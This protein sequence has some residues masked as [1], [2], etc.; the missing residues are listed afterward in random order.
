MEGNKVLS[1]AEIDA[2]LSGDSASEESPE[3]T[4]PPIRVVQLD[5]ATEPPAAPAP[6]PIPVSPSMPVD[7]E[8]GLDQL[9][10]PGTTPNWPED[11]AATLEAVVATVTALAQQL[12]TAEG[13]LQQFDQLQMDVSETSIAVK[14]M[15]QGFQAVEQ[16]IQALTSQVQSTLEGLKG[17]FGYRAK[18]TFTCDSCNTSGMVATRIKCTGCGKENWWGWWPPQ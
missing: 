4:S 7:S 12:G 16:Q 13:T 14:E 6:I 10:A 11:P 3:E 1:Q 2:M 8:N 9:A 15:K 18:Q 5:A 17:T